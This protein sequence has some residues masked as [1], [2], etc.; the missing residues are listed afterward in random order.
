MSHP[1]QLPPLRELALRAI[2]RILEGVL[3]PTGLFLLLLNVEG[4]SVAIVGGFTWSMTVIIVRRLLGRRVP[5]LVLVGLGLLLLRTTVAL[6]TG[7]SFLYFLQPTL[8][9]ATIGLVLL[10]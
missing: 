7:S 3:I 4:L 1:V 9:T 10:G 8:G 6:A 5:T 2:P